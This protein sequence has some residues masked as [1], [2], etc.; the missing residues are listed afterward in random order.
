MLKTLFLAI[1]AIAAASCFAADSPESIPE[2]I[3]AGPYQPSWESLMNYDQ[4]QWFADA[5]FGIW[6]HWSAQS[7]PEWG[8]W[9]A[10]LMYW[11][12]VKPDSWEFSAAE[13]A[14]RFHL[15]KYGHPSQFGF[16]DVI[17]LWKADKFEPDK[18]LALYKRAGAQY[19]VA[20][21]NHHCNFD[22]WN[23]RYHAWNSVNVGPKKDLIGLWSK[24]ARGAG[25][26]FGVSIHAARAWEW[27]EPAQGSDR[28]GL[29]AGVPY[30]GK[31]TK[32][33]GKGTWW[34]GLDPQE[35]YAQNHQPGEKPD[36]NYR[37]L[38][39]LRTKDLIDNYHPDLIYYDDWRLP[40]NDTVGLNLAAH[41]YNANTQWNGV[42]QAVMTTKGLAPKERKA[43]TMDIERGAS[44]GIEPYPWQSCSCIGG[45][46]Y[47]ASIYQNHS[48]KSANRVLCQLADI[49]SRNGNLLLSVP[50]RG[51][52]S[53]DDQEIS[54][55]EDLAAWMDVNSE[56]V[57]ASRPWKRFGEGPSTQAKGGM[58]SE[59]SRPYTHRDVRFTTRAGTLYAIV[60]GKPA[61]D[62]VLIRSLARTENRPAIGRAIILGQKSDAPILHNEE[63]LRVTVGAARET[64][65]PIVIEIPGA[66]D[67]PPADV[68][69]GP[70][71]IRI[72]QTPA[73][74]GIDTV[75]I[76]G[77][78][79]FIEERIPGGNVGGW[80]DPSDSLSWEIT[81][82]TPGRYRV[83]ITHAGVASALAIGCG[84]TNLRADLPATASYT[85]PQTTIAGELTLAAGPLKL[86]LHPADAA[87]WRAINLASVTLIPVPQ[88]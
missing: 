10:R 72:G 66:A 47:N 32:A 73:R 25:L 74:L 59:S 78:K 39:Y 44:D 34:E 20:L 63:G 30:D 46:H 29:L 24:A 50:M 75:T 65:G 85:V 5:K 2:P 31:L 26:R 88:K 55:L 61:G 6:A 60:L 52:G 53:I 14:Y 79:A 67:F 8:D 35:L 12:K 7:Q 56:A 77:K 38:F 48:Y 23:S 86:T 68:S 1:A 33:D 11:P 18:L 17:N 41:F 51:D 3:A 64:P 84:E 37:D 42:N 15:E 36:K 16:K 87:T 81:V 27:Y 70:E 40:I 4:P 57:F 80:T 76:I 22:A 71:V 54:I 43:L 45:W 58:F 49:V 69:D 21:A 82:D 28:E 13:R 62:S 19:F 83:D 9:Y